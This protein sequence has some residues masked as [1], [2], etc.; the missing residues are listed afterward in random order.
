[1]CDIGNGTVGPGSWNSEGVIIF[2]G[3]GSGP[4]RRVSAD[5]GTATEITALSEG[6]DYHTD[7]A[8][9]PD[10][11]HF[12]Y[13][14]VSPNQ[15]SATYLGS[16][17]AKATEQSNHRV[18]MGPSRFVP[19]AQSGGGYLVFLRG[20]TLMAQPFDT[21]RLEL[22]GAPTP[23]AAQVGAIM[24][25]GFFAGSPSELLYR[26]GPGRIR[27]LAWYDRKGAVLGTL[28]SPASYLEVEL[29]PDG[30]RVAAFED[31][32]RQDIWLFDLA[33]NARTRL[34]F[35]PGPERCAL[36]SH[37]GSQIVFT[38]NGAKELYRKAANGGAME[39]LLQSPEQKYPQDWSRDGRYLMYVAL[40]AKNGADLWVLPLEGERKP[41]KVLAT[42]FYET[43][44]RFSP[45]GRW[46]AYRSN[47]SGSAQIYVRPF[48][49]PGSSGTAANE[50]KWMISNG[51]GYQPRWRRDG[52]EILYLS[53]SGQMMSVAVKST[54][55]SFQAAVPKP[56][57]DAIPD[58]ASTQLV[59]TLWDMTSDGQQFLLNTTAADSKASPIT[60]V[61]NWQ[62]GL[63]K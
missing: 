48:V 19:A 26:T 58:M 51:G 49:L 31:D 57:F 62:A 63:K 2:G 6:E 45:D 47:E 25:N 23:V 43:Q 14:R 52:K 44:A 9:L 46:I 24:V 54:G 29:S 34:T 17:D 33:R 10:A 1:L 21:T 20:T 59:T 32:D 12:L 30:S 38:S 37:D 22:R 27:Q 13:T 42:P 55:D 40:D 11:R 50:S 53:P 3:G 16:L 28:G 15:P 18:L 39:L 4:L 41:A 7:P 60:V 8:W 5:G 61:L 56:L 36:W 35:D